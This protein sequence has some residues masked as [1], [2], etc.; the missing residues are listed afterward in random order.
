VTAQPLNA[1][2]WLAR[3]DRDGDRQLADKVRAKELSA[4]AAAV[5]RGWR[6]PRKKLSKF[7]QIVKWLPDLTSAE[8]RKL[9]AIWKSCSAA[10]GQRLV[11]KIVQETDGE[12]LALLT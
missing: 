3:L 4:N 11:V 8:K 7:E 1:D 2:H 12:R 5:Q 10:R 9:K 6:K